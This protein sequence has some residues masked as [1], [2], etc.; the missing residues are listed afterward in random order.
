MKIEITENL[1]N[2]KFAQYKKAVLKF[3]I[4]ESILKT[5]FKE[6]IK[7]SAHYSNSDKTGYIKSDQKSDF[8]ELLEKIEKSDSKKCAESHKKSIMK[9]MNLISKKSECPDCAE[10]ITFTGNHR[11]W[12]SGLIY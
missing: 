6:L 3:F 4:K 5:H 8:I 7:L 11:C 10:I 2:D 12:E 9:K 1:K